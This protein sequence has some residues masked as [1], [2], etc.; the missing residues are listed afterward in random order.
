MLKRYL[1]TSNENMNIN[2]HRPT[3]RKNTVSLCITS[4]RI[5]QPRHFCL[6]ALQHFIAYNNLN[7]MGDNL[8]LL[9]HNILPSLTHTFL[10]LQS[11]ILMNYTRIS[12]H[13]CHSLSRHNKVG[14]YNILAIFNILRLRQQYDIDHII[15]P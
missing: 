1:L 15:T 2:T 4:P 13:I 6:G 10:Q 7:H 12:Y 14:L 11:V 5:I 3:S 8:T 9:P